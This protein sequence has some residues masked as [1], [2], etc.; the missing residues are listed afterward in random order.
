VKKPSKFGGNNDQHSDEEIDVEKLDQGERE[1]L[2]RIMELQ[3][4]LPNKYHK[5]FDQSKSP[6]K[7][8]TVAFEH[9]TSPDRKPINTT[10]IQ[11]SGPGNKFT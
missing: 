5:R 11:I 9:E 6:D 1:L 8:G 3:K 10:S 4:Y 7:L 2:A